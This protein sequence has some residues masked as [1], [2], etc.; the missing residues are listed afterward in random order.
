MKLKAGCP[1]EGLLTVCH[2]ANVAVDILMGTFMMLKVLLKL[3][4]LST[5]RVGALEYSVG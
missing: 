4:G 3:E 5:L 2:V 1:A